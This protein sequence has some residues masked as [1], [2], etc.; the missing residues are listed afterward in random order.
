MP[1]IKK[2][3]IIWREPKEFI[4]YNIILVIYGSIVA[5]FLNTPFLILL[6]WLLLSNILYIPHIYRLHK[7]RNRTTD[8]KPVPRVIAPLE[9][10]GF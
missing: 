9:E 1:N 6:L 5:K 2:W 4:A 7:N 8:D 10:R 3:S